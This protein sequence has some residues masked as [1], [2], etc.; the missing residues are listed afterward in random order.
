MKITIKTCLFV[1]ALLCTSNAA[2]SKPKLY[3][4]FITSLTGDFV[5]SGGIT[6]VDIALDQINSSPDILP[7]H[8]LE[9]TEILD[10]NVS[11]YIYPCI[12]QL[13]DHLL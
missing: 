8:F 9:Y 2:N 1:A 4:S 13:A 3:F 11:I 7:N 5:A 10:S 12:I 6:A